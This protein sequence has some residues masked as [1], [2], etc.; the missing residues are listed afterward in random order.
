MLEIGI[1]T[2][3]HT[4]VRRIMVG[5]VGVIKMRMLVLMTKEI[6]TNFVGASV[7][8][9]GVNCDGRTGDYLI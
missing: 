2:M 1:L 6:M 7:A 3:V 5:G 9:I 4:G 8:K